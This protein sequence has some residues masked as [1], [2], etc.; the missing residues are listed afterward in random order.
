MVKTGT[1]TLSITASTLAASLDR[2][3]GAKQHGPIRA[4][5]IK[6]IDAVVSPSVR[7]RAGAK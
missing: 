2:N 1:R 5:R 7:V 6:E 4:L 3:E